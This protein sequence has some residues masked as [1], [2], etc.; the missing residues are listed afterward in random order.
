MLLVAGIAL[1]VHSYGA[2]INGLQP[3]SQHGIFSTLS[4]TGPKKGK[5]AFSGSYE[6]MLNN[7]FYRFTAN[8]AYGINDRMLFLYTIS[9]QSGLEDVALG[10]E[11]RV[12]D[13]GRDA[14]KIAY[15]LVASVPSNVKGLSTGG[16]AG[17]GL[18]FSQR[19]GPVNGHA[20]LIY[21]KPFDQAFRDEL[22]FSTGLEFSAS[23]NLWLLGELY[24][25]SGYFSDDI[26]QIETRI[27]YRAMLG[28]N[29]YTK[30]G[31]GVDFKDSMSRYWFMG[32][33]S[34]LLP[35]ERKKI[36]RIYEVN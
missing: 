14:P 34:M 21:S 16:S 30:L 2:D 36:K 29:V 3:T 12:Y 28:K 8:G 15:V 33:L 4:A 24:I 31:V 35:P 19:L 5:L 6:T 32:S 20:N 1:P 26:D 17:L 23:H 9:D 13:G 27:G 10:F 22:R 18:I 25:R 7:N 11:H